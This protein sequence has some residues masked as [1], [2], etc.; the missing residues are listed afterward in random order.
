VIFRSRGSLDRP[1]ELETRTGYTPAAMYAPRGVIR[2]P[3]S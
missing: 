1:L 2:D 3:R